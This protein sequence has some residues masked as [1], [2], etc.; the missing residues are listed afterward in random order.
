MRSLGDK[1]IARKTIRVTRENIWHGS[2]R[3][4]ENCPIALQ[5]KELF[6]NYRIVVDGITAHVGQYYCKLPKV[7]QDFTE[8]IDLHPYLRFF[9]KPFEFS[10]EFHRHPFA[11]VIEDDK[12]TDSYYK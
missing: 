6:P 8:S 9:K 11:D 12:Y 10:L 2:P 5:L 7:A 3:D 4:S 1:V